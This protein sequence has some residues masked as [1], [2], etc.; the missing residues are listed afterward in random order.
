MVYVAYQGASTGVYL[1]RTPLVSEYGSDTVWEAV[2]TPTG[3]PEVGPGWF[4]NLAVA[5]HGSEDLLAMVWEHTTESVGEAGYKLV[6]VAFVHSVPG[7]DFWVSGTFTIGSPDDGDDY[8]QKAPGVAIGDE[9]VSG[10]L[11]YV[12]VDIIWLSAE[13]P[14]KVYPLHVRAV[15]LHR[16]YFFD[17][18]C[19]EGL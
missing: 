3:L 5:E 13:A 1:A 18:P 15:L 2:V 12:P 19:V 17:G 4:A 14:R 6:G 8:F 7:S 16:T 10:L 9:A 11:G